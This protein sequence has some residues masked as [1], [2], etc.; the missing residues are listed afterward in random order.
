MMAATGRGARCW[1]TL[2]G[3]LVLVTL[4]PELASAAEQTA[5]PRADERSE[6]RAHYDKG[7]TAYALGH[8][9]E[10]AAEFERAFTL[11]ADPAI[12]YNAAQAY[13]LA[14]DRSRALELY[15]NYLRVYGRRAEHSPD[16]EWHIAELEKLGPAAP[17]PAVERASLTATPAP[18]V[19]VTTQPLSPPPA[20][21][22]SLVAQPPPA[23][24]GERPIYKRWWFWAGAGAVVVGAVVAGV[25]LATRKPTDCGPG[26]D[27]C[28]NTG[29]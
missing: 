9:A 28:A 8:F 26:V 19:A 25:V 6:A 17:A 11:K 4:A 2:W 23:S 7:T 15:K 10:A 20:A 24:E 3:A 14:G 1:A 29:L 13:R 22:A 12:L 21:Q 27:Y 18:A 5:A 16:V